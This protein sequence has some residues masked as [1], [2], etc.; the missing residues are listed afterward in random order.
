[1]KSNYLDQI[2][3]VVEWSV[4]QACVVHEVRQLAN[5]A[6]QA[7]SLVLE[8]VRGLFRVVPINR[9][10]ERRSDKQL[11]EGSSTDSPDGA[12]VPLVK[13]VLDPTQFA[14]HSFDRNL[15]ATGCLSLSLRVCSSER[16]TR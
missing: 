15:T 14:L 6:S 2:A 5:T 1:M 13:N 10:A 7:G 3:L 12:L 9:S 4:N 16:N 8:L 11:S